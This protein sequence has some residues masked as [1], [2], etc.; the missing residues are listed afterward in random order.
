MGVGF[1]SLIFC[2]PAGSA[3]PHIPLLYSVRDPSKKRYNRIVYH[4]LLDTANMH[5]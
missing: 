4:N 5:P 3:L 1:S 2:P